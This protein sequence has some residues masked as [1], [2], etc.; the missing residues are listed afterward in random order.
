M[1]FENIPPPGDDSQG[2]RAGRS[3]RYAAAQIESLLRGFGM[4]HDDRSKTIE[5]FVSAGKNLLFG[6][7]V[8]ATDVVVGLC[9]YQRRLKVPFVAWARSWD[10]PLLIDFQ[11]QATSGSAD[12]K[13]VKAARDL[14]KCKSC[15]SVFLLTGRHLEA[16]AGIH[17]CVRE[18]IALSR[19]KTFLRLFVGDAE[20]RRWVAEGMQWPADS[21]GLISR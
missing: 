14:A 19:G 1:S 3:G 10:A 16:D 5:E 6:G 20:F 9:S 7:G 13:I 11:S 4:H 2:G 8:Y 18:F 21:Q 15:C 12:D 17:A